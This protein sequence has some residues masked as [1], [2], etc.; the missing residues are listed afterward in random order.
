MVIPFFT[1]GIALKSRVL[2][3]HFT[4][5]PQV[6]E[7]LRITSLPVCVNEMEAWTYTL[8][9]DDPCTCSLKKS[10]IHTVTIKCKS[11]ISQ[12]FSLWMSRS[13]SSRNTTATAIVRLCI[14]SS[15]SGNS[16]WKSIGI[17]SAHKENIHKVGAPQNDGHYRTGERGNY[18][19]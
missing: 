13:V 5:L 8:F 14:T 16:S 10:C 2:F 9:F 18:T 7:K 1:I 17:I 4:S 19:G 11:K 6:I 12:S 3:S 15:L